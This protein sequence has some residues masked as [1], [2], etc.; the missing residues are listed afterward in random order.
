[1]RPCVS[2]EMMRNWLARVFCGE[3]GAQDR[4]VLYTLG[5]T[6]AASGQLIAAIETFRRALAVDAG[7]VAARV[8][9]ANVLSAIGERNAA[10]AELETA[11]QQKP[12]DLQ[13]RMMKGQIEA[14]MGRTNEAVRTL[15]EC[16]ER[17]PND[18]DAWNALGDCY[19]NISDGLPKAEH[20]Y[21]SALACSPSAFAAFRGLGECLARQRRLDEAQSAHEAWFRNWIVNAGSA[22]LRRRQNDGHRRG[23]PGILLVAMQ[24]SASEYIRE[25][26]IRAFDIPEIYISIGTIPRDKVIP[27]AVRQLARGGAIARSHMDG[28]D[29]GTLAANGIT[30]MMLEVRDP[31][32]VTISWTHMMRRLSDAE[33]RYASQMYDPGVPE[34]FRAWPL[35]RQLDWAVGNYLPGQITWLESWVAV[36]N[37]EPLIPVC[38]STY[39]EFRQDEGAYFR[40]ISEFYKIAQ[41]DR[42]D[43]SQQSA[44]ALRNFRRGDADEWRTVL[45]PDQL[46]PFNARLKP[47][48]VRFGWDS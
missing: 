37:Q 24:K 28:A 36:L 33:F 6:Q 11:L 42:L 7:D 22:D 45:T 1:M 34:D 19:F 25:N 16:V 8:A 14:A 21:R 13:A 48:V 17:S 38:V 43:S 31:R 27:S 32:Q 18:A 35:Q 15:S 29:F 12:Q 10:L 20:A 9:H 46:S 47:L 5:Q 44:A 30:R 4:Q 41:I 26:L 40:R 23:V 39:E 2:G 3:N